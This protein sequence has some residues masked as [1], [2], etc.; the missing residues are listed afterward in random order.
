LKKDARGGKAG[1]HQQLNRMMVIVILP[2][3]TVTA[4]L[5]SLMLSFNQEY[6][7]ALQ[8]ANTAS[9]F[10]SDFKDK[11]DLQ[12]WYHIVNGK[13][14]DDLPWDEVDHAMEVLTKLED[15]TANSENTWRIQRMQNICEN[16]RKY[17]ITIA[18]TASYDI[19]IEKLN[20]DIYTTTSLFKTYMHDYI[21]TEV[22]E[23][24]RLQG[25][26][27]DRAL[28]AFF[29]TIVLSILMVILIVLYSLRFTRRITSPIAQLVRK[30]ERLG[31]G[32]FT[33]EPIQ[34]ENAEMMALDD[35]FNEMVGRINGLLDREIRDQNALHKAELELLQAQI[36]PHFLY[37]TLDSIVW[38]AE[39]GRNDEVVRMVTS[40]SVFFRNSLSKGQDIITLKAEI[41]QVRSYLEIQKIRYSDILSY[42]IQ[43]GEGIGEYLAPK[44]MLQPLVENAIYHGLKQ[45][46]NKG[47]IRIEA[48][49]EGEDLILTVQDNGIGMSEER[50]RALMSGIYDD[51]HTG[52]GLLNVHKRVKLHCGD[53]YGLTFDSV[54]G[55]GTTVTVRLP[56]KIQLFA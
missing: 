23:L 18:Q 20:N 35:G 53:S 3:L 13:Q 17:M 48:R 43:I 40:L 44:L 1:I 5:L 42:H 27:R 34:T 14:P 28:V 24:S 54:L 2:F 39:T 30:A 6:T 19:R 7:S 51:N 46:R 21:Y 31:N 50:V 37:N 26:I 41:E 56:K 49:Q 9:E 8:N 36:N 11:L 25:H 55:E 45:K 47:E 22:Q 10:N 38:L 12:M 16:L 52:L 33:Q 29:G 15:T 32:D 4:V